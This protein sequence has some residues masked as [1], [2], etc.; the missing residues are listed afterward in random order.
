M[1]GILETAF[2]LWTDK[3]NKSMKLILE[4][5]CWNCQNRDYYPE[6]IIGVEI[7]CRYCNDKGFIITP[8]GKDILEFVAKHLIPLNSNKIK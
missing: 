8:E 1:L 6:K 3:S 5:S 7:P 2:I 4:E